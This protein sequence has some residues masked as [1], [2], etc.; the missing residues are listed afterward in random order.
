MKALSRLRINMSQ[1]VNNFTQQQ[2]DA[3]LIIEG[4][5]G[6]LALACGLVAVVMVIVMK[7]YR[8]LCYRLAL[9]QVFGASLRGSGLALQFLFLDR[10]LL[11]TPACT[12]VA[13]FLQYAVCLELMFSGWVTFHLFCFVVFYKNLRKM[14]AVYLIS[15]VALPVV[16]SVI[17]F[18]TH[19]YGSS[20]G[21]CWIT[22]NDEAGKFERVALL[23]GPAVVLV[24]ME[25]V[26]IVVIVVVVVFR[27]YRTAQR[28]LSVTEKQALSQMF[29]LLAY[30]VISCL[31]MVSPLVLVLHN[32]VDSRLIFGLNLADAISAPLWSLASSVVL[33]VHIVIV[34]IT[35]ALRRQKR[36][37]KSIAL[38]TPSSEPKYGSATKLTASFTYVSLAEESI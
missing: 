4:S 32:A 29:P 12:F 36:C 15:S 11:E 10:A 14:E 21:L 6:F 9:Y 27:G 30:P 13:F 33:L 19:S 24:V 2:K 37:H 38:P 1:F 34:L 28:Q 3:I 18:M 16:M 22:D 20:E 35:R 17:P 31:A 7:L 5:T 26:A 23:Y 25:T 8:Q